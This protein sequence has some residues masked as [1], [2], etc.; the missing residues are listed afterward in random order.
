M[1]K[2]Q[3]AEPSGDTELEVADECVGTARK[4]TASQA[5]HRPKPMSSMSQREMS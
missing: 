1:V 4:W 2:V 5:M 3:G